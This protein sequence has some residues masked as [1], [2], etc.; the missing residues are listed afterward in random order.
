MCAASLHEIIIPAALHALLAAYLP[1]LLL[2]HAIEHTLSQFSVKLHNRAFPFKNMIP[3]ANN[4]TT[5][6][7]L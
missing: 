6:Y 4:L 3:H 5:T 2:T 1:L 7:Y